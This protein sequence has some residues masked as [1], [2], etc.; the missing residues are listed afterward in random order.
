MADDAHYP[1]RYVICF[2]SAYVNCRTSKLVVTFQIELI[3]SGELEVH[4]CWS[5]FIRWQNTH[6]FTNVPGALSKSQSNVI[7]QATSSP[8]N[9]DERSKNGWTSDV[10]RRILSRTRLGSF[11][12]G[13]HDDEWTNYNISPA[14]TEVILGEVNH[15]LYPFTVSCPNI[16]RKLRRKKKDVNMAPFPSPGKVTA[17]QEHCP[18]WSWL[19]VPSAWRSPVYIAPK[20][21]GGKHGTVVTSPTV[22]TRKKSPLTS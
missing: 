13:C 22:R 21:R 18:T 6:I 9:H 8:E 16:G 19:L 15:H 11:L 1:T 5:H 7:A 2:T 14:C 4:W 3:C 12:T 17:P 20:T 10:F